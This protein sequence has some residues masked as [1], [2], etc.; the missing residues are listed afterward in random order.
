MGKF[1]IIVR[2]FILDRKKTVTSKDIE[3]LNDTINRLYLIVIFRTF[4]SII[5]SL[6]NRPYHAHNA[7]SNKLKSI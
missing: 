5:A 2:H 1:P 7:C 4:H 6:Q 3:E